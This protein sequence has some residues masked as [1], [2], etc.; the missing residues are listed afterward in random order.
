ME[1]TVFGI[2]MRFSLPLYFVSTPLLIT[3]D[4]FVF[5]S[6]FC[7]SSAFLKL[8]FANFSIAFMLTMIFLSFDTIN[9]SI[10]FLDKFFF[11]VSLIKSDII[12]L[13]FL[14]KI[15][16]SILVSAKAFSYIFLQEEGIVISIKEEQFANASLPITFTPS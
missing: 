16:V 9:P 10:S 4:F 2:I 12:L 11:A 8:L 5:F 3:E 14:D 1:A 15:K 7:L 6:M 13:S